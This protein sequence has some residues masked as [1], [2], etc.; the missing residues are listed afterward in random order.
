MLI[1]PEAVHSNQVHNSRE[2]ITSVR[3]FIQFLRKGMHIIISPKLTVTF[4]HPN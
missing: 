4:R 1:C 3:R 2:K